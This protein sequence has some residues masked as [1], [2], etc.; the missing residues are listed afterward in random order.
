MMKSEHLF[1]SIRNR[2]T[3]WHLGVLILTL[4]VYGLL[5]QMFLWK[6]L[7]DELE[8]RLAD[9]AELAEGFLKLGEGDSLVWGGHRD[10]QGPGRWI[11]IRAQNGLWIYRNYIGAPLFVSLPP[12]SIIPHE[13]TYH[14]FSLADGRK[15]MILQETHQVGG[16]RVEILAAR[17]MSR[18]FEEMR[19][20]F[21]AQML[22]FP[23]IVFLAWGGGVFIAGR[24]LAPLKKIIARMRIIS[25][26]RL[27]ERLA[28]DNPD[29]ELGQ[30]S[31]TFNKL[32]AKLDHSFEQMKLFTADASHEL[33]TPLAA[34]RSVGEVALRS[35]ENDPCCREAIASMLE[36][37]E[38]MTRLVNDLL[39]LAR[40]DSGI[41]RPALTTSDLG[42]VVEEEIA[43]LRVLAEE[44]E[45]RIL[46]ETEQSCPVRLDRR[47]FRQA[48]SNILHNA[49]VYTPPNGDIRVLTGKDGD[50]VFVEISDSGPGISP[51]HQTRIFDR[52][53][54]V[55]K[56]RSRK[57]GG[58]GLGLAIAKWAVEIHGGRIE[59]VSEPGHGSSFRI[60]LPTAPETPGLPPRHDE[61]DYS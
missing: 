5:S 32:M 6:Q 29:D 8:A 20:L 58:T 45:Q 2:I 7:A 56:V 31:I 57:T 38:K 27:K 55:D 48:F 25:A 1:R 12:A 15:L 24:V 23:L 9:D 36:E 14:S 61:E 19:H 34:I 13:K 51:E 33:R 60:L 40:S 47:I 35:P 43:L 39:A 42:Q 17:S 22:L 16:K 37:V 41:V 49:I 46:V 54:R 26:D 53:Y 59:L 50:T 28:V 11:E 21:L 10:W 30:L 3:L 44:K 4:L 52:F 18:V